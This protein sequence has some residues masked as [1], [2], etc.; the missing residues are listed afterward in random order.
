VRFPP[1]NIQLRRAQLV[2]MLVVLVP[3]VLMTATGILQLVL[4]SSQTSVVVSAILVLAFCTTGIT[5]YILTTIFVGKG[6]SLAQVQN[7]FVSSVSHE[8]RTPLTS[9]RLLI[10][11]LNN[12]RLDPVDRTQVLSLLGREAERLE[13][14]VDRV[15][16]LSRLQTSYRF[17]LERV[18]VA[19]T[20][21]ETIAAFDALTLSNPTRVEVSVEPGLTARIDQPMLVRALVNL[22]TN[23]WK[24]TGEE[25][26]ISIEA[27]RVGRWIEILVHDN[28]IGIA[29]TEHGA[30]FEQFQRG[31]AA[32]AS[33]APGVGLGLALVRAIV[34]G[35]RGKIDLTSRPGDT[36]FRIRLRDKP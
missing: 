33:G 16:E 35:H 6:A 27:R 28:G 5:G 2:L 18:E 15:L 22:L 30:I 24:Y 1:A 32:H 25:K 9:I 3:T 7:D 13:G 31:R 12:N 20:V 36:T 34:R 21:E 11:S 29:R 23:A 10:E 4:S 19:K 8:L 17:A 26:K 14:L